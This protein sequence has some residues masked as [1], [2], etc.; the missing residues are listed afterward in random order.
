MSSV[1]SC[2][3]PIVLASA[4]PRRREIL[5]LSGMDFAVM[6][7]S[8]REDDVTANSPSELVEQLSVRKCDAG[9]VLASA[10]MED[11]IV[12]GADTIVCH[13]GAVLGKPADETEACMML[14]ALSGD[15]HVVYTGVSVKDLK[16]GRMMT[17][18]EMTEVVFHVL[19][20]EEILA[21]VKTG[22]PLDK[23]GAYGIQ[24][25][26]AYLVKSIHGDFYNVV[27]LPY[28]KLMRVLHSFFD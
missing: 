22:E 25:K 19:S 3:K 9:C 28:A 1:L 13:R 24:G 23:A 7:P 21:Y 5:A 2:N 15:S 6:A 10:S 11:A 17:F 16:S 14:R 26:G 18:H 12:I 8:C 27:G 20:E 4:S